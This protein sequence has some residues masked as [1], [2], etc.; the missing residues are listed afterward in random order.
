M[1]KK[2]PRF[3]FTPTVSGS[4]CE[5]TKCYHPDEFDYICMLYA[6]AANVD[7]YNYI[8][9]RYAVFEMYSGKIDVMKL[10]SAFY[11][12]MDAILKE[13]VEEDVSFGQLTLHKQTF[14]LKDKISRIQLL[15]KGDYFHN[16]I[17]CPLGNTLLS[18]AFL[19]L[20]FML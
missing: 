15:W 2:V 9:E 14:L 11:D 5:G 12:T 3:S 4:F 7:P 19:F 20:L 10:S 16:N 17:N 18:K 8:D 13:M 6:P 1:A